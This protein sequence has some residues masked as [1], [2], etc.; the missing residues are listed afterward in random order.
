MPNYDHTCTKCIKD[1]V[2]E[3]KI[4]EVGS[5]EIKCPKCSSSGNVERNVTNTSYKAESV[6]RY[7]YSKNSGS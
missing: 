5:I 6:D 3:M 2:V 7:N 1:F 4:S